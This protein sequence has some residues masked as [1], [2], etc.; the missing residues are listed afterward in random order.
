M[1]HTEDEFGD[2]PRFDREPDPASLL[3]GEPDY[4]AL[5]FSAGPILNPY[6]EGGNIIIPGYDVFGR[7]LTAAAAPSPP[8]E[9]VPPPPLLPRNPEPGQPPPTVQAPDAPIFT[10]PSTVALEQAIRNRLDQLQQ[11][12]DR[13]ESDTLLQLLASL[14]DAPRTSE[15][16]QLLNF[17][18]ERFEMLQG[19]PFSS[20]EEQGLRVAFLDDIERERTAAKRRRADELMRLGH[21]PSSG[22]IIAALAEIDRSFDQRRGQ[23]TSAL[24]TFGIDERQRRGREA[25]GLGQLL[26]ALT[27]DESLQRVGLGTAAA[28]TES[29][30]T[31]DTDARLREL[32]TVS[33]LPSQMAMDRFQL[34]LQALGLGG[35]QT[36]SLLQGLLGVGQLGVQQQGQTANAWAG[37]GQLLTTL[38]SSG[39]GQGAE[40]A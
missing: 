5:D 12:I 25:I 27:N 23:A 1:A 33:A 11:P 26:Q 13:P 6:A 39:F 40:A 28:S 22:T 24:L 36:N 38:A 16:E 37:F 30:R 21:A 4:S 3:P 15:M 32:L 10:D 7:P 14:R 18:T 31:A 9:G 29:G 20:T 8:D 17:G 35:G 2:N 34:A 19:D